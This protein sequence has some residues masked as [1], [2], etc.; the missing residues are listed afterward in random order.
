MVGSASDSEPNYRKPL[1]HAW[2]H[3][4]NAMRRGEIMTKS[5]HHQTEE[6]YVVPAIAAGLKSVISWI[7]G[8]SVTGRCVTLFKKKLFFLFFIKLDK[9]R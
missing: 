2:K 1:M 7:L 6:R 4:K 5:T 8:T 3:H 9:N